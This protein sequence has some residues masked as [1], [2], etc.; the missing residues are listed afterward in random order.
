MPET[1]DTKQYKVYVLHA[2]VDVI[3]GKRGGKDVVR[4]DR[5]PM[6]F[7]D[8]KKHLDK[9]VAEHKAKFAGQKDYEVL[10]EWREDVPTAKTFSLPFNPKP[11]TIGLETTVV[12]KRKKIVSKA[13]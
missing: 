1:R 4:T 11:N 3:I 2:N 8:D 7:F 12:D 10:E 5:V 6:A 13:K 9:F